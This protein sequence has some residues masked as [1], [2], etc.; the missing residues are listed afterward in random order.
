MKRKTDVSHAQKI[1]NVD[2]PNDKNVLKKPIPRIIHKNVVVLTGTMK[3]RDGQVR[4][5]GAFILYI[6]I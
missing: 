6:N 1:K 2:R 4:R 3:S 5:E